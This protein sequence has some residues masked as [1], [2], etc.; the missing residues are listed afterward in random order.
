MDVEKMLEDGMGE[1]KKL[2]KNKNV[3]TSGI[4]ALAGYLLTKDEDNKTRNVIIGGVI[5]YL[6]AKKS[7]ED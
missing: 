1:V 7:E 4:G 3:A 6:L 2:L 5:G